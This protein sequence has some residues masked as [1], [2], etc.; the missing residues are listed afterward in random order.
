MLHQILP[1]VIVM[2]SGPGD[3]TRIC[4]APTSVEAS[5]GDAASA[6]SAV[7]DLFLGFLTGPSLR[8]QPLTA[9]LA[10][11]VREEAHQAGCPYLLLTNFKHQHKRSGGSLLGRMA[12]GAAQ[13][14]AWEAGVGSGTSAGR[15]AGQAAYGAAGQAAYNYAVSI[16][17]KDEVTLEYRLEQRDGTPVLEK[18][19]TRK[20]K[21]DGEDLL[22]PMAQ[23]AAEQ[24]VGAATK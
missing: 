7:R 12:A 10:S 16:H 17:V 19:N 9:K 5:P 20:A 4:L 2:V 22:T 3:T 1:L 23:Q 15:I 21:S 8:P 11:Q 6:A 13:Q 24:I 18:R 14:G